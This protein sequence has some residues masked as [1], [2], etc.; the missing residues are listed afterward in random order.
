MCTAAHCS[1][2]K[3]FTRNPGRSGGVERAGE[4]AVDGERLRHRWR[5]FR[6]CEPRANRFG[7][8]GRALEDHARDE[9]AFRINGNRSDCMPGSGCRGDEVQRLTSQCP[10]NRNDRVPLRRRRTQCQSNNCTRLGARWGDRETRALRSERDRDESTECNGCIDAGFH[11]AL[12]YRGC[13][14][15]ANV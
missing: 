4:G 9:T 1:G 5:Q 12:L 2:P 6:Q 3:V 15:Q 14:A 7:L 10:P 11:Q 13:A 8:A